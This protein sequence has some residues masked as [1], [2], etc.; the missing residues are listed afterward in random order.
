M[1]YK[2]NRGKSGK[3]KATESEGAQTL[4]VSMRDQIAFGK[5]INHQSHDIDSTRTFVTL[6]PHMQQPATFQHETNKPL[7]KQWLEPQVMKR[8][9]HT[10]ERGLA[11]T[12][13]ATLQTGPQLNSSYEKSQ[14]VL[15]SKDGSS[16]SNLNFSSVT[17]KIAQL[18]STKVSKFTRPPHGPISHENKK[19]ISTVKAYHDDTF[20][21]PQSN[22]PRFAVQSDSSFPAYV[23]AQDRQQHPE[24]QPFKFNDLCVFESDSSQVQSER[25]ESEAEVGLNNPSLQN[26]LMSGSHSMITSFAG[27]SVNHASSPQGIAQKRDLRPVN[28]DQYVDACYN[29]QDKEA[30]EKRILEM[31]NELEKTTILLNKCK[32]QQDE[33][34]QRW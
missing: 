14:T 34:A 22:H 15:S 21:Q 25:K 30:F 5:E 19:I 11:Q 24:R 8:S 23:K 18:Q 16:N 31:D 20:E 32:R 33:V 3:C 17:N 10:H 13:S 4:L 1:Y 9:I 7:M 26:Y 12:F 2:S 6:S 29:E 28:H 27:L